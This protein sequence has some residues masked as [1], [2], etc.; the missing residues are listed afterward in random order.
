MI[1]TIISCCVLVHHFSTI[2]ST[3]IVLLLLA[4][5]HHE[6]LRADRM[7]TPCVDG[8]MLTWCRACLA[9]GSKKITRHYAQSAY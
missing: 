5:V 2:R 1:I 6:F 3:Q 8:G 7:S 9:P 4:L